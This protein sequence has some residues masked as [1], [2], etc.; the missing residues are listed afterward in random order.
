MSKVPL[1]G[2]IIVIDAEPHSGREYGGHES[3][4]GNVRRHM[5]VMSGDKY[6]KATGMILAMPITTSDR[7]KG[8]PQYYQLLIMGGNVGVKGYVALWQLQNFDFESRNGIII[9]RISQRQYSDLLPFVK[10]MLDIEF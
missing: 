3:K 8:N 6:N 7:Y 2:D 4:T 9:N 5:V 1:K 10:D